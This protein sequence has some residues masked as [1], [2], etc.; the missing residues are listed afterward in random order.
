MYSE[1][2]ATA[3]HKM[4]NGQVE[5]WMR[6]SIYAV[7]SLWLTCWVDAGEP[8]LNTLIKMKLPATMLEEKFSEEVKLKIRD[9]SH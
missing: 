5:Q 1:G 7:G 4:L 9:C 8:D 3:Y 2:Y 6:D